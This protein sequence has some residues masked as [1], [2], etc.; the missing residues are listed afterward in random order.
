MESKSLGPLD[1]SG[2]WPEKSS[3]QD[4]IRSVSEPP[5]IITV[6]PVFKSV[7]TEQRIAKAPTINDSTHSSL[8]S[9]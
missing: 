8:F 2:P 3:I 6:S 7:T 9:I 1:Q 4:I 5:S